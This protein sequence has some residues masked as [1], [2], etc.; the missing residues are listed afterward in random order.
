MPKQKAL[1]FLLI[2]LLLSGVTIWAAVRWVNHQI[3]NRVTHQSVKVVVAAMPIQAGESIQP[4]LLKTMEWPSNE[5]IVGGFSD[6]GPLA[7]R[8]AIAPFSIGEPILESH[9][10]PQG[11]RAGLSSLISTGMRA[12]SVHVNDVAGVAGFA[13]PGNFVDVLVA[14]QDDQNHMVSKIVLQNVRVLAVAQDVTLK[15]DV[16]AKVVNAVTLEVTPDQAEALDL[17]K[18]VGAVSLVLRNQVDKNHIVTPGARKYELLG[19][20][21]AIPK[22]ASAPVSPRVRR[23]P[24]VPSGVEII[25][26]TSHANAVPQ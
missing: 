16:K 18:S 23:A 6:I 12:I 26:G 13:L 10:A 22:P 3:S 19:V 5:P 9:L 14:F 21:P 17:A 2:S 1:I 24:A 15:D 7:E 11:S 8:V 20:A 25:R 4:G